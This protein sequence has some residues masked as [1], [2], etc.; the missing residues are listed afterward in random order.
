[1][2]DRTLTP[3]RG[4]SSVAAKASGWATGLP[5]TVTVN[6]QSV[7]LPAASVT[8]TVTV[9]APSAK[10]VPLAGTELTVAPGQ[11]SPKVANG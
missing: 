3:V 8:V 7:M 2:A 6:V 9:V 11:L 4:V 10:N 5:S 1:M